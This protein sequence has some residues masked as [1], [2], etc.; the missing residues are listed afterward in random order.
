VERVIIGHTPELFTMAVRFKKGGVGTIH[1]HEVHHQISYV[2]AGSFRATIGGVDKILKA[3]D[4]FIAPK[5]VSHGVVAL[6][7]GS[8]LIDSFSPRRDDLAFPEPK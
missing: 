7:D 2:A 4:A 1:S 8:L 6:E 3:G 5:H